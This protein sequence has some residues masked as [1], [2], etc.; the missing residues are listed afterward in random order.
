MKLVFGMEGCEVR[1]PFFACAVGVVDG[2]EGGGDV[3][4]W[5]GFPAEDGFNCGPE[6]EGWGCADLGRA[7]VGGGV[8]TPRKLVLCRRAL[9]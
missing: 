6:V 4:S 5:G 3:S 8:G 9:G 7:S 1:G 2:I